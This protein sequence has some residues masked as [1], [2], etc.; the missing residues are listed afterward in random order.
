VLG[1][2]VPSFGATKWNNNKKKGFGRGLGLRR[3]PIN[4]FSHNNQPKI[5]VRDAGEYEGEV[6]QA[7]GTGEVQYHSFGGVGST[8][9]NSL[10]LVNNFILSHLLL[11]LLN[12]QINTRPTPP[13]S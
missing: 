7:G 8:K 2:V 11:R 1:G 9:I 3:L 4:N 13:L 6:R 10:S 12:L 5:G